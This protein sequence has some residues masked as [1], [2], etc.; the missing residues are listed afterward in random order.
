MIMGSGAAVVVVELV[1]AD[2]VA[3]VGGVGKLCKALS[4]MGSPWQSHPGR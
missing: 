3:A 1:V 4:S 2:G